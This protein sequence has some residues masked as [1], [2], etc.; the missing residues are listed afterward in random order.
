VAQLVGIFG[1]THNPFLPGLIQSDPEDPAIVNIVRD[2]GRMRERLRTL[3]PD[4]LIMVASDHLNEWFNDNMPAF[5]VGKAASANGPYPHEERER[6]LARYRAR[7]DVPAARSI[8]QQGLALGVD[9]SFS[10]EFLMDH[11]FT[12]PLNF[13]RPEM[14]LPIVPIWTN[15]M[16][17]P[18]PPAERFYAVGRALRSIVERLDRVERVAVLTSGHL[19]LDVGGPMPH[20]DSAD[21]AFDTRM[22]ALIRKG[23]V[24][25]ILREASYDRL[26]AV[27]NATPGFLNYVLILGV[28]NGAPPT[29]TGLHFPR[30]TAAAPFMIWDLTG[31]AA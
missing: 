22:M 1:I 11:A 17:P 7:V 20:T 30:A 24:A 31:G 3:R 29:E 25:T 26:S 28:A 27:G 9:F 16:A 14:D 8:L 5:L 13:L 21:R 18:L 4:L 23:E 19:A 15:V 10:D 2:Y 6:G 12:V